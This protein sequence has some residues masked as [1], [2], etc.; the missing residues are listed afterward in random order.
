M[1]RQ[2]NAKPELDLR[3][4]WILRQITILFQVRGLSLKAEKIYNTSSAIDCGQNEHYQSDTKHQKKLLNLRIKKNFP[5][6]RYIEYHIRDIQT[7]P[8]YFTGG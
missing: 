6:D 1:L 2:E 4:K 3:D 7:I 8:I 5:L